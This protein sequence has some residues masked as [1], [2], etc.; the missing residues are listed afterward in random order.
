MR[1]RLL[2]IESRAVRIQTG[3]AVIPKDRVSEN[4]EGVA[5]RTRVSIGDKSPMDSMTAKA[6]YQQLTLNL[7][8]T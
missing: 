2:T 6:R 8:K 5:T 1:L 3:Q 4:Y 7:Q